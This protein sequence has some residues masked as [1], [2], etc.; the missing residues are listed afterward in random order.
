MA[1]Y[2]AGKNGSALCGQ[3]GSIGGFYATTISPAGWNQL[4]CEKK[5]KKCI[6]KIKARKAAK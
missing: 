1:I 2:H 4:P 6:A 3:S 5:C